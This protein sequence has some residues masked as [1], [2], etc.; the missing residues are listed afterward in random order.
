MLGWLA[1][2]KALEADRQGVGDF[3]WFISFW[4]LSIKL[5]SP[6]YSLPAAQLAPLAPYPVK[7]ML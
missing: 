4:R 7:K 3:Q 5:A 6:A 1:P 2:N